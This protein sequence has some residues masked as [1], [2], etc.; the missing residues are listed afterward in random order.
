MTDASASSQIE[1]GSGSE[2]Y[3]SMTISYKEKFEQLQH[4]LLGAYSTFYAWKALQ[5]EKYNGLYSTNNG[6]WSVVI[7]ALQH[8]WFLG[9]ARLFEDSSYTRNGSVISVYSLISEHPNKKRAKKAVEFLDQNQN[10]ITNISRV[11]DHRHAHNNAKFLVNPKEFEARFSIKYAELEDIFDFSDKLL[12][13]LHPD[14]GHGYML[15]HMKEEAERDTKDV[16]DGLGYFNAK[17]KAHREKWVQEG[18]DL[19]FSLTD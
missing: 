13:L 3:W 15:G 6:F 12:G 5:S 1:V 10:V 16:M 14:D 7:P 8:E 18:G 9:L 2:E 17:R 19:S 4:Q 11:R